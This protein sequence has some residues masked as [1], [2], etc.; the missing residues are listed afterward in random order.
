MLK[1]RHL[2]AQNLAMPSIGGSAQ[3]LHATAHNLLQT[4]LAFRGEESK[5]KWQTHED[6]RLDVLT[7][8]NALPVHF[9]AKRL[10]SHG[11]VDR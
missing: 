6:L 11:E 8:R 3:W 5:R 1:N 4:I 10:H 2:A 9:A 7:W